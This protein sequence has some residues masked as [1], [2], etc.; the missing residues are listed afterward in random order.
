MK[1][2]REPDGLHGDDPNR[3]SCRPDDFTMSERFD[4]PLNGGVSSQGRPAC[5][6]GG[7]SCSQQAQSA[8][9][10]ATGVRLNY[11]RVW[12]QPQ[13]KRI[14]RRCTNDQRKCVRRPSEVGRTRVERTEAIAL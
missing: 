14:L 11:T 3:N 5:G 4:A 1:N 8:T 13:R 12:K 7:R 6:R 2:T 9:Q 10:Q